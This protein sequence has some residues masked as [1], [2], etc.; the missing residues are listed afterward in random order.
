MEKSNDRAKSSL[1]L[2]LRVPRAVLYATDQE[3]LL[4]LSARFPHCCTSGAGTLVGGRPHHSGLGLVLLKKLPYNYLS[5]IIP[6]L[7]HLE[8]NSPL[9]EISHNKRTGFFMYTYILM[10]FFMTMSMI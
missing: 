7:I 8:A 2:S 4:Q 9:K 3:L 6:R 10:Y 1:F 5:N